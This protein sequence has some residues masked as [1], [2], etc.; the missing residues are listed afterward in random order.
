[1][2]LECQSLDQDSIKN[3]WEEVATPLIAVA[4]ATAFR[5][6]VVRCKKRFCLSGKFVG[7][8]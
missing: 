2:G 6:L 8:S 5:S 7:K 4:F 1:M 3:A